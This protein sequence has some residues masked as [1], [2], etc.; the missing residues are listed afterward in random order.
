MTDRQTDRQTL[1]HVWAVG[2]KFLTVTII[3][4]QKHLGVKSAKPIRSN[5]ANR[6]VR[7]KDLI[8][9]KAKKLLY[10]KIFLTP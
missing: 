9:A 10:K 3:A 7:P 4:K 8:S 1:F 2:V 5:I 6:Q